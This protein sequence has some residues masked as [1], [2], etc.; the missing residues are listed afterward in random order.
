MQ[1]MTDA[2]LIEAY[3]SRADEGAFDELM[4]RHGAMVYRAC[5]RLL[6]DAHEAEDA[7]QAVFV[8]LARKAG[9]LRKGDLS[10]WLYRVAHHVA[11]QT[12]RRRMRRTG[13]EDAYVA[14]EAIQAGEF[15]SPDAAEPDVLGL[16]D[17]ALLSLPERYRQAVVLRYLQN[18]SEKEAAQLAGVP[19]GT[20]S[21]RASQ[22][23]A[24]LRERLGKLG[25]ATS[26]TALAGLLTSEASAAVP[27]TLLPSILASVK[28][29]AATTAT[30]TG[31]TSTA[32]M[33][34][35]GA[36]KAMFIVKVKTAVLVTAASLVV[37]GGGAIVAQEVAA[38]R[39]AAEQHP[40]T[41]TQAAP[42]QAQSGTNVVRGT[43]PKKAAG[44]WSIEKTLGSGWAAMSRP[45]QWMV[46]FSQDGRLIA[47]VG[48][49]PDAVLWDSTS[50]KVIQTLEGHSNGVRRAVFSPDGAWLATVGDDAAVRVWSIA[51]GKAWYT[52]K[53]NEDVH[54]AV[55]SPDGRFLLVS[56]LAA[57]VGGRGEEGPARLWNVA[58]GAMEAEFSARQHTAGRF[59]PDGERILL[60]GH[61]DGVDV[62]DVRTHAKVTRLNNGK[63]V[64]D[65]AWS[66]DGKRIV[67]GD[68]RGAVGVWNAETGAPLLSWVV[69]SNGRPTQVAFSPDNRHI[70]TSPSDEAAQIW[71][72]ASGIW[73]AEL[74]GSRGGILLTFSPDGR[75]VAVVGRSYESG[76]WNADTGVCSIRLPN[77]TWISF[78][79]DS[80]RMVRS[81]ARASSPSEVLVQTESHR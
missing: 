70:A 43:T 31:T 24:M 64:C 77:T 28:T 34:A 48:G 29:A 33:L 42:I 68:F 49:D 35:K 72:A 44:E 4:R 47:E 37:A 59:S 17:T 73:V 11:A 23:I 25:V 14:T 57:R 66:P 60:C 8:V 12:V 10:A 65:A 9:G 67:A 26:V 80:K 20:I 69:S 1:T 40:A 15:A 32:V 45:N 27:E 7:S 41:Q 38:Q 52:W 81:L 6:K 74:T 71:D 62:Y 18:H 58:S 16:L 21:G 2:E 61:P 76:V 50:G 19:L 30:A 79:P 22:G 51:T 55:F 13:R 3:S 78:S 46:T 63:P 53:K 54:D 39:K 36:M 75:Y 56:H 5:H